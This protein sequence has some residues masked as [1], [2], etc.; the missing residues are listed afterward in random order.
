MIFSKK[1]GHELSYNIY[2]DY[3]MHYGVKGMKWGKKKT[4]YDYDT[5][6]TNPEHG[7]K[8]AAY[9]TSQEN[10]QA[11]PSGKGKTG[12]N[13]IITKTVTRMNSYANRSTASIIRSRNVG[14]NFVSGIVGNFAKNIQIP[15]NKT[16]KNKKTQTRSSNSNISKSSSSSKNKGSKPRKGHNTYV[17]SPNNSKKNKY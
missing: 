17:T 1:G 2:E 4:Y 10:S 3:L 15:S 6:G 9:L 7:R 8:V 12:W 11:Q 5:K 13:N 16:S 14:Q